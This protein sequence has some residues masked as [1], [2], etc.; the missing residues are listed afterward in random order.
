MD[1]RP[2]E[3]GKYLPEFL[4][5]YEEINQILE[6]ENEQFTILQ[7]NLKEAVDNRYWSTADIVGVERFE[8]MLGIKKNSDGILSRKYRIQTRWRRS[9]PYNMQYLDK[10]LQD[11]CGLGNYEIILD[12]PNLTLTVR[13]GL[14][15]GIVFDEVKKLV[16][17]TVPANLVLNVE[18]AYNKYSDLETKTHNW[19]SSYT[20]EQLRSEDIF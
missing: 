17:D 1:L 7:G 15:V 11:I 2:I 8:K 18:M 6:T 14:G 5:E 9:I 4:K 3:M 12:A 10:Q 19:L 20:H 13:V 16:E